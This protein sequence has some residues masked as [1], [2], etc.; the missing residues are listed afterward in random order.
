M[1]DASEAPEQVRCWALDFA[2][3]RNK[4]A[5]TDRVL[6]EAR[7]FEQFLSGRPDAEIVSLTA[8]ERGK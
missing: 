7:R 5:T 3:Q 4:Y 2:I 6:E 8:K 1:S